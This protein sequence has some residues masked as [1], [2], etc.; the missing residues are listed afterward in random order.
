MEVKPPTDI[1]GESEAR[2]AV[3]KAQFAY[4]TMLGYL[5][6]KIP[7]GNILKCEK[8]FTKSDWNRETGKV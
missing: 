6:K 3:T 1:F 7:A 5:E 4:D 2:E 8:Q